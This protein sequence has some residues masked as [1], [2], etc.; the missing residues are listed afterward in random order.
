MMRKAEYRAL[1]PAN[2]INV[3]RFRS[4]RDGSRGQCCFA[5]EASASKACAGQEMGD[6][7]QWSVYDAD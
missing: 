2:D 7:F 5:V 4:E 6:R 1:E 3:G